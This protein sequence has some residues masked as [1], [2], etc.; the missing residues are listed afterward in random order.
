MPFAGP[1][2]TSNGCRK[3]VL[4]GVSGQPASN[5][6]HQVF[7][8]YLLV[9]LLIF[10]MPAPTT[11]L[12]DSRHLDKLVHFGIFLGF[13]L[14]LH[15][16]YEPRLRFTLLI[17]AAFAAGIELLQWALPYRT[18]DWWDFW[19]GSAGAGAGLALIIA[20]GRGASR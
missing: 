20:R 2:R 3:A 19:A 8:G 18:A 4:M 7:I 14:L 9:M 6:R 17:S 15:L 5:R 16:D 12:E 13:A 1:H 10:L 11:P